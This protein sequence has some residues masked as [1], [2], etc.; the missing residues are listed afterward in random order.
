MYLLL[1]LKNSFLK[2]IW[3]DLFTMISLVAFLLC[4]EESRHY[5][6][7]SWKKIII[8]K[9]HY[10]ICQKSKF[11]HR[12]CFCFFIWFFTWHSRNSQYST[13]T[14]IIYVLVLFCISSFCNSRRKEVI[15]WIH[16][17]LRKLYDYNLTLWWNW[18]SEERLSLI[19]GN[20][21][22][23]LNTKSHFVIY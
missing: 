3:T 23:V 10:S 17:L 6:R 9:I 14:L 21:L 22:D 20:L 7:Y 18:L 5:R 15:P 4:F 19:K 13:R 1:L 16:L 8:N 12:E 11:N 2:G